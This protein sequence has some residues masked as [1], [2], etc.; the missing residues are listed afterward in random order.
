MFEERS[1]EVGI[2]IECIERFQGMQRVRHGNFLNKIFTAEELDYCFSKKYAAQHLAVRF[3]AKEA[4]M[5]LLSSMDRGHPTYREVEIANRQNGTPV[6]T[7]HSNHCAGLNIKLSLSHC[8]GH[9]MA[10]AVALVNGVF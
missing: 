3:A 1:I 10:V 8:N 7:L 9:A 6:V 5:K 2:D 4:T